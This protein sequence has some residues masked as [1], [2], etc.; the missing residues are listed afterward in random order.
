VLATD[1]LK[2]GA[3]STAW[4]KF[5]EGFTGLL[6]LRPITWN[7][8]AIGNSLAAAVNTIEKET[9]GYFSISEKKGIVQG[10][11]LE[12]L[13]GMRMAVAE[14]S[15]A[16]LDAYRRNSVAQGRLDFPIHQIGGAFGRVINFG[17]DTVRG[18][19]NLFK[20]L[21]YNGEVYASAFREATHL[22]LKSG[23]REYIDYIARRR[24]VPTVQTEERAL[25][26][27]RHLTFQDELGYFGKKAQELLQAGPLATYWPFI[28]SGINLVKWGWNRTPGLQLVSKSL[29]ED[30]LAGGTRADMAIARLT[31]SNVFG[32]FYHGIFQTGLGTGGGPIDLQ[33]RRSWIAAHKPY[34]FQGGDG[35]WYSFENTMEPGTTPLEMFADFAEIQNQLDDMTGE[36]AAMAIGLTLTRDVLSNTWWQNAGKVSELIATV[37]TGEA[38]NRMGGELIASPLLAI[39]TGGPLGLAIEREI[40]PVRRESRSWLDSLRHGPFARVFGYAKEMPPLRDGYGDPVMVPQS[41][42]SE[43]LRKNMALGGDLL[44]GLNNIGNPFVVKPGE[45]DK[46]KIEGD[47][48]Q[49][50]MPAFPWS[51]GGGNVRDDFDLRTALPGDEVPVELTPKE[52]DRWITIYRELVRDEKKQRDGG[53][54]ALIDHP[55]YQNAEIAAQRNKFMNQ[56]A[57]YRTVA[58]KALLFEDPDLAKKVAEAKAEKLLPMLNQAERPAAEADFKQ[59]LDL[60]NNITPEQRDNLLKTGIFD[61]GEQ[62]DSTIMLRKEA[63]EP[64]K[65]PEVT[66]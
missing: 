58:K 1:A 50:K 18:L 51:T 28:K 48:L 56:L 45:T 6:L 65:A 20:T 35:T 8:Q 43:W 62:R 41:V 47:R 46:I 27:A 21:V 23:S 60:L 4:T 32:Q 66:P 44:A 2:D 24:V 14:A 3:T 63:V 38:P 31:L 39:G 61:S 34:S 33:E 64:M 29:Y 22:G 37:K 5:R 25:D 54:T 12:F 9:A 30:I 40:D 26:I 11:G 57:K 15:K 59:S 53:M 7:R 42:G 52:R 19:D 13:L 17:S 10:E 49:I 16:Y 36:Q 55:E